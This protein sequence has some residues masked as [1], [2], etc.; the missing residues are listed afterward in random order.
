MKR[1]PTEWVKIFANDTLDK[2]LTSKIYKELTPLHTK[3][4][5]TPIKKWAKDLSRQI[6]LRNSPGKHK[7]RTMRTVIKLK[8]LMT[9]LLKLE[10]LL[11]G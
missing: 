11:N 7:K 4:T 8:C 10:N 6:L 9:G 1:E 2:G 5:N 3:K